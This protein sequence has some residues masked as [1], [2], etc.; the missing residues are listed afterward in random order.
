MFFFC[1]GNRM[2]PLKWTK[3]TTWTAGRFN[4]VKSA[5]KVDGGSVALIVFERG[6]KR[7][8]SGFGKNAPFFSE[9]RWNRN[10][11]MNK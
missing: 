11:Y 4:S 6:Q 1:V 9:S 8:I 10:E 5:K 7:L 2:T 3:K